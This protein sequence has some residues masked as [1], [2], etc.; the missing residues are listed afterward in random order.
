M[1]AYKS[2]LWTNH[3]TSSPYFEM[4]DISQTHSNFSFQA[5]A[6][7]TILRKIWRIPWC[8]LPIHHTASQGHSPL[9]RKLSSI[10]LQKCVQNLCL[11]FQRCLEHPT[12]DQVLQSR[13][14]IEQ[15]LCDLKSLGS[16]FLEHLS[17]ACCS[18]N[19]LLCYLFCNSLSQNVSVQH[20]TSC[21][22]RHFQPS[23][24]NIT[25]IMRT[26]D[27]WSLITRGR[28]SQMMPWSLLIQA[29]DRRRTRFVSVRL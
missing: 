29:S 26:W 14:Y 20:L 12:A 1:G 9:P 18:E 23:R 15:H 22:I 24:N 28:T 16:W 11:N 17:G 21:L 13:T 4:L 25:L 10:L 7:Q 3:E 2:V 27:S 6:V 8:V 5:S 19:P